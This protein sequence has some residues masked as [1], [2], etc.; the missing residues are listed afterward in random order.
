MT[1]EN[2][3]HPQPQPPNNR[4][5]ILL[6]AMLLLVISAVFFVPRVIKE[7]LTEKKISEQTDQLL[8]KMEQTQEHTELTTE[9]TTETE[10]KITSVIYLPATEQLPFKNLEQQLQTLME[11][12]KQSLDPEQAALL[13][14]HIAI[15]TPTDYLASYQAVVDTYHWQPETENFE[16]Q[17][18]TSDI[19]YAVQ[20]SQQPIET[21]KLI[22]S[23][24]NLL[25]IR[26]VI[27]QKILDEAADPAKILTAVLDLPRL[28][29]DQQM[30]YTPEQLQINLPTNQTGVTDIALPYREIQPF[31]D[32]NLVDPQFLAPEPKLD[33]KKKYVALTFDDGPDPRTTPKLLDILAEKKVHATFFMLGQNAANFPEIVKKVSEQGHELANHSYSHPSLNKL[34]ADSIAKEVK[35]TDAAIYQASGVL[36]RTLRPPYGAISPAAA[37]VIGKPIIQW[38]VDSDDWKAKK[39]KKTIERVNKTVKSGGIILLH[40]IHS[41]SVNATAEIIDKLQEQGFEFVT[42]SELLENQAKPLQQYFGQFDARA[43]H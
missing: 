30:T 20:K 6:L 8:T 5:W 31:I 4:R 19:Q 41:T 11:K 42:V 14:G 7:M 29:F 27:Q 43:I 12:E 25:G 34:K 13:I 24:Q 37:K 2:Q 18:T 28:T 22:G 36:P 16:Q 35:L 33:P 3:H 21:Q 40:D 17:Q 10:E 26:Q 32:Q 15:D 38:N 9:T 1:T 39:T 23:E